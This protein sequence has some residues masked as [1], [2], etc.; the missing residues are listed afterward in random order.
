MSTRGILALSIIL[1]LLGWIGLASFTYYNPPDAWNKWIVMAALWPTFLATF[2]PVVYAL[3]L[4]LDGWE[5][6]ISSAARQSA[7]AAL[8]VTL[9]IGLRMVRVLNWANAFLMLLLFIVTEALLSAR[10]KD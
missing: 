3:H 8:F 2:L 5:G 9:C 1:A 6:V 7:L 4:R 10:E